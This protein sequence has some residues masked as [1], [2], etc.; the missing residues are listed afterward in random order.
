M[1]QSIHDNYNLFVEH[2]CEICAEAE[3]VLQNLSIKYKKYYI[4]ASNYPGKIFVW[5][6]DPPLLIDKETIPAVP[7]LYDKKQNLL[8]C[9]IEAILKIKEND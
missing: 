6:Q 9:G 5:V 4:T 8:R 7:A 3:L 1:Q 2:S